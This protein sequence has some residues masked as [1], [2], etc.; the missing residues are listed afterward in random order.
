MKADD[1]QINGIFKSGLLLEVPFYQRSYVWGEEEWARLLDDMTTMSLNREDYFLGSLILKTEQPDYGKESQYHLYSGK[2]IVVDGQQRLTTLQILAKVIAL[3]SGQMDKFKDIFYLSDEDLDQD[4]L[5]FIHNRYDKA[6]F[7]RVMDAESFEVMK[8]NGSRVITA[9]NYFVKALKNEQSPIS[10]DKLKRHVKFVVIWLDNGEDEQQIFDTINSLGMRLTTAELLK[11]F[12]FSK[13]ALETY[14]THWEDVFESNNETKAY[15]DQE[16]TTGRLKRSMIDLF[17]SAFLQ[18]EANKTTGVTEED[19]R[20]YE[21]SERLFYSYRQFVKK[22]CNN[23]PGIII[24]NLKYS[25]ETFRE[26]FDPSAIESKVGN[27][28]GMD[29][30]NVIIFGLQ[31]STIISY[32]LYL[33]ENIADDDVFDA[34]LGILEA[35][36][37][38]RMIVRADTKNYNRFYSSLI[39]EGIVTPES[40]I[41]RLN[42]ETDSSTGLPTNS[43]VKKS[44]R[45]EKNLT[46]VQARGILYLLEAS[47]RDEKDSTELMGFD[48]YSLEHLMPQ[49]W[50]A[51]WPIKGG[52]AAKKNRYDI[53]KT[54]G[55]LAIITQ[56]LNTSVS[57]DSWDKKIEGHQK[58]GR[59]R[60][61]PGLRKCAVGLHTMEQPLAMKVW[62]EKAIH[63][64]A[65]WLYDKAQEIWKV[66]PS[67]LA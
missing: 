50:E 32:I 22:Y 16:I 33:R 57:N 34:M 38:R 35:Y 8:E 45:E 31:N 54:L 6:D 55:N 30:M 47:L 27:D 28:P 18:L 36:I 12:F 24:Y 17:F 40:L 61:K 10:L 4:V 52:E 3:K 9:F 41:E 5:S 26:L 44:F 58:E 20:S 48:S 49:K 25:A 29:R 64:R 42:R 60:A 14:K 53:L 62:D 66:S 11:N 13:E 39:R 19:R 56:K 2:A 43:E 51:N 46:S 21:K 23:D 67:D 63:K 7:E 65:D 1:E 59:K 37:M 15:W